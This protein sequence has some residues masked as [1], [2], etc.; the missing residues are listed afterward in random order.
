MPTDKQILADRKDLDVYMETRSSFVQENVEIVSVADME[1]PY[2][3]H[4]STDKNIKEF[5][6]FIGDR[7]GKKEDRTTPKVCV[8]SEL[9]SAMLGYAAVLDENIYTRYTLENN[10]HFKGG[11]VVYAIPYIHALRPNKKLVWDADMSNE[12]WLVAYN[13]A[14]RVYKPK[15]I[16]CKFFVTS[17]TIQRIGDF[18]SSIEV[19]IYMEAIEPFPV[20]PHEFLDKG[21]WYY[22][23]PDISTIRNYK[24]TKSLKFVSIS[25]SEYL[26]K[27]KL[28]AALLSAPTPTSL[29]N[30]WVLE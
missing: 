12:H 22:K 21:Y 26:D 6:P 5:I 4:I 3:L 2:M 11:Y 18:K 17:I 25:K 15:D 14:S 27:K 10:P 30:K 16:V 8:S 29:V 24:S 13:D 1:Y 28:A 7:Q 9:F 20:T 19:E 23:G